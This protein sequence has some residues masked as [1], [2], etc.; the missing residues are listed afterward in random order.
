M[1]PCV[2][3]VDTEPMFITGI[4]TAIESSNEFRYAGGVS[5][6]TGAKELL[7]RGDDAVV[8]SEDMWRFFLVTGGQVAEWTRVVVTTSDHKEGGLPDSVPPPCPV[9]TVTRSVT[10]EELL[11]TLRRACAGERM[12]ETMPS[13][14]TCS[15]PKKVKQPKLTQ[16]EAQVFELVARRRSNSEI[17][18]ILCISVQTVKNYTSRV[19]SKLGVASRR[20][21]FRLVAPNSYSAGGMSRTTWSVQGSKGMET[22]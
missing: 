2:S 17:A 12:P 9:V 18:E 1:N 7:A 5:Y 6:A 4:R 11:E 3:V 19:Y 13:D 16:R 21:V 14:R 15:V 22:E 8:I 20:E 10:A